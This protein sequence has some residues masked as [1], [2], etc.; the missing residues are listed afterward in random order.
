M[1]IGTLLLAAVFCGP[2]AGGPRDAKAPDI[3]TK[4]RTLVTRLAKGEYATAGKDFDMTM[5]KVCPPK[6][7]EEIWKS[8]T[9]QVGAL[10]KQRGVRTEKAGKYAIVLVTC[11]F[12]KATLDVKVSFN[13]DRE[14]AGLFFVPTKPTE[15]YKA[16]DYADQK[17]FRETEIKFGVK[18]WELPGTLAVPA[19]P[20]PFP[21][22]VLV[23]GS[24]PHDRDETI[25]PNRP[26][27]DL[28]WAL[29]SRGVAVLRYEK[30]TRT[31][32]ARMASSKES[33][34]VN[35]E[36][37]DDALAAVAFVRT[38]RGI[39]GKR[40]FVLG[41][42]LGGTLLPAIGARDK[43]IAG[44]IALAGATRNIEDAM[45]EQFE[46]IYSL[47][48]PLSDEDK[49]ELDKIKKQVARLKDPRRSAKAP[50]SELPLGVPAGYWRSLREYGP[51]NMA[52]RARQPMLI[53]QGKRD[54]QVTAKDF[55]G[56]KK[57]LAGR[58][59]VR[60]KIYPRLNHLF[61]AGEGKSK[62]QEYEKAGHVDRAVVEDIADWVKARK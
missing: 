55:D 44:L 27:K 52:A 24:G 25:G 33:L 10:K 42:S 19:G 26:F 23:H 34:G 22:V 58:D 4:A 49:A 62:P 57:L 29:A 7:L 16:P 53:L 3:R 54:Y 37:I 28:A 12:A 11:T 18:G 5:R 47:K 17:A 56:W 21:A 38:A 2:A 51:A 20:G 8:L 45:L 59:N 60:F 43:E 14:V 9:G 15:K 6:K 48:G 36:V 46:Y 30:R 50:A 31:H 61:I 32:G 35:E 1:R 39:D 40:V 13:A 41:H